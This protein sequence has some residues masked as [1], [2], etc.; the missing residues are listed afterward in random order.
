MRLCKA[1]Y[2][3]LARIRDDAGRRRGVILTLHP[4]LPVW[5]L[6]RRARG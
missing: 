3:C 4:F 2:R 5:A 1:A 6:R